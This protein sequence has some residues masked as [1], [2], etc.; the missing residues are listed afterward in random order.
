MTAYNELA[1]RSIYLGVI[2]MDTMM[3]GQLLRE[4][5][6]RYHAVSSPVGVTIGDLTK[7]VVTITCTVCIAMVVTSAPLRPNSNGPHR[8]AAR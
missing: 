8:R 7:R 2:V 6:C 1:A 3:A 5:G 4:M